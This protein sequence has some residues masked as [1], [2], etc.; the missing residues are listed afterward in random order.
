MPPST[1]PAAPRAPHPP[2][3]RP[4]WILTAPLWLAALA[5]GGVHAGPRAAWAALT[6]AIAAGVTLSLRPGRGPPG[7]TLGLGAAA[8]G[9]WLAGAISVVPLSET[10]RTSLVPG[11]ADLLIESAALSGPGGDASGPAALDAAAAPEAWGAAG[12]AWA[13]ALGV[14]VLARTRERRLQ[15]MVGIFGLAVVLVGVAAAH[16]ALGAEGAWG[17]PL[18][19]GA[20]GPSFGPF[21]N[22]NH[23]AALLAAA[24]PLGLGLLRR[25]PWGARALAAVGTATVLVGLGI[26]GSRGAVAAAAIGALTAAA[27]GLGRPWGGALGALGA[28]GLAAV[29]AIGPQRVTEGLTRRWMPAAATPEPWGLRESLWGE[30]L[31]VIR[32]APWLGAGP[33]GY[34][35]A[36]APLRALSRYV[37]VHHAHNEPLQLLAERGLPLGLATA[38][39][40]LTPAVLAL[41]ALLRLAPGRRRWTLSSL[42]GA[43]AAL[44]CMGLWDFPLR[45][46]AGASLLALLGGA[47]LGAA[48]QD[49]RPWA[50]GRG[51]CAALLLTFSA[52]A[53][54]VLRAPLIADRPEDAL[55]AA[56]A[57]PGAA[58]QAALRA[59][60]ARS[61]L[62]W[63]LTLA[64]SRHAS[65]SGDPEG[66]ARAA[67]LTARLAP[68]L[69]WGHAQQAQLFAAAGDRPRSRAAWRQALQT[70]LPDNDAAGPWI[71]AALA[72][73]PDPGFAAS[74][75]LPDRG[76]RLRAGALVLARG[77]DEVGARV[78]FERALGLEPQVGLPYARQL[79]GWGDPRRALELLDPA[80]PACGA[81]LTRGE[82]LIAIGEL[83]AG[84]A[85]LDAAAGPCGPLPAPARIALARAWRAVED[86]RSVDLFIQIVDADPTRAD[87]RRELIGALE[88]AGR[89]TEMAPH[90]E[91]LVEAGDAGPAEAEA[92][93]RLSVG[94]PPR[95][96]PSPPRPTPVTPPAAP[97]ER[98]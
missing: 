35:D 43:Y 39:L 97:A 1:D 26:A 17:A 85:L 8:A 80:D 95:Y 28:G 64:L 75:V 20:R 60:L 98:P 65:R 46:A 37:S 66:A 2:G 71:E 21:V 3:S 7:R 36:A 81:R 32:A 88:A 41:V 44:L 18:P 93:R 38:G 69:P 92:L 89:Y 96:E 16:R 47:L 15:L 70:N 11:Y 49:R 6:V 19:A 22:P 90:L 56:S 55:Q 77:G 30:A 42:L 58:S 9:L 25:G 27:L 31:Q 84:A 51:A 76:D 54:A 87:R 45:T 4:A 14:A 86:P 57:A 91:A 24:L 63:R 73:E 62:D 68:H 74:L 94:L 61:P 34:Q 29:A 23:G 10:A 79:V 5:W 72:G 82:A 78:L 33:G 13:L 40:I 12:V 50:W 53:P 59:A 48:D 52:G 67:A 83:H